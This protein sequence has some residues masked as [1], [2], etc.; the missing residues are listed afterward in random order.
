M[1]PKMCFKPTSSAQT[2]VGLV[3]RHNE[4]AFLEKPEHRLWAIADGMGGHEAGAFSSQLIVDSLDNQN[5][6][7]VKEP[8]T[9]LIKSTL[10]TVNKSLIKLGEQHERINGS[11]AIVMYL[12]EAHCHYIWA[13]D[14]RLYLH[15]ENTLSQLTRDHSQAEIYV[16]LGMLTREE[17]NTHVSSNLLTRCIGTDKELKLD[18]GRCELADGDRFLLS[19][20]GLDKH[21]T[22]EQ[23]ENV[24]NEYERDEA[25]SELVNLAL[26]NG[27]SD[28]VTIAIVDIMAE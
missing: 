7:D 22:H 2:H 5:K 26:K 3:R 13:G 9:E 24:L 15:R 23:V 25:L 14:S 27:G 12:D 21:V 20:D 8:F 18:S 11:T 17:A 4:D 6:N 19:S 16:E 28:N 1:S 10:Y